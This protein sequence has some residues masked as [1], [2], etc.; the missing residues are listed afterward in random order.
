MA[1]YSACPF[2]GPILGPLIASFIN[3]SLNWRWTWY[4]STIWNFIELALIYLLVP[5]TFA[6]RMLKDK[7]THLRKT[8]GNTDL[9]SA[10]ELREEQMG[11]SKLKYVL[12]ST[13]RPFGESFFV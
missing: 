2:L 6:P 9:R 10:A 1:L 5:E 12:K 11:I 8:T 4:I 7:A 13:G 3:Q